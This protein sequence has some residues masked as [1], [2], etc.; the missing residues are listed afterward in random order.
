[1]Q[2]FK[3]NLDAATAVIGVYEFRNLMVNLFVQ[4]K[5]NIPLLSMKLWTQANWGQMSQSY[6]LYPD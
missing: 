2:E 4:D 5:C 6:D 1:M 3:L